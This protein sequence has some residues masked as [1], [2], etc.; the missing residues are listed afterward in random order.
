MLYIVGF[1]VISVIAIRL[2]MNYYKLK[3]HPEDIIMKKND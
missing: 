2:N 1:V 3:G